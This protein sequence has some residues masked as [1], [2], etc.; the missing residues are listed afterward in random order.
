M[1]AYLAGAIEHAPDNGIAWRRDVTQFLADTLGHT[2]YDPT[3]EELSILSQEESANFR[4]YKQN[5]LPEYQRIVRKLIAHDLSILTTDIDY[6]I[7]LWDNY[8]KN[9]G[10]TQ[11][12]ITVS[13]LHGIPVY[14]VSEMETEK[15]SGWIL[16]CVSK[17]FTSFEELEN[18]LVQK[19]GEKG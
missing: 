5:N 9:G 6:V 10:G 18:H 12:E 4:G 19:Y 11:G 1:K 15:I 2:V 14:L 16:G 17:V 7:C 3:T 13:H 8:V